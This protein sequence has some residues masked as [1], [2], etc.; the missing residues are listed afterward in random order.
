V[1]LFSLNSRKSS[2]LKFICLDL[3]FIQWSVVQFP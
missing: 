2:F 3:F 1:Y